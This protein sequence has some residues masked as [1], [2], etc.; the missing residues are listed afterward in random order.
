MQIVLVL[1]E[2]A[3]D[4]ALK[5]AKRVGTEEMVASGAMRTPFGAAL[6]G[7]ATGV[8]DKIEL[9]LRAAH[10]RG[11]QIARPLIDEASHALDNVIAAA[12]SLAG[13]VRAFIAEK[14]RGFIDAL[15]DGALARLKTAIRVGTV[16]LRIA[17]A[18]D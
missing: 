13:E 1:G 10:D 16:E 9:A 15:I 11:V 2:N 17:T 8:W 6:K 5:A 18:E 3:F 14:L 12:G 7:Q 4:N